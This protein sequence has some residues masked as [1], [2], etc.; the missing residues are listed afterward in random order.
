MK[1]WRFR[2]YVFGVLLSGTC[3]WLLM[4]E[5]IRPLRKRDRANQ[6]KTAELRN[7]AAAARRTIQDVQD[8]ERETAPVQA[9]FERWSRERP[10]DSA[11]VW[12]PERIS[13]HFKR[14]AVAT[15]ATRLNTILEDPD[16]PGFQRSFWAV[17]LPLGAGVGEISKVLL[18]VSELERAE[19]HVRV[20]DFAIRPAAENPQAQTAVLNCSTLARE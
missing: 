11:V 7:E 3:C 2:H 15:A 19:R 9:E 6:E 8:K 17:E 14:F 5:G 13:A 20:I 16:L 4:A 12:F 18:A 10:A 1:P